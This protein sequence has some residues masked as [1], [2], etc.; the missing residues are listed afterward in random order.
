MPKANRPLRG[1]KQEKDVGVVYKI[2]PNVKYEIGENSV[3]TVLEE[4]NR[5][6][7]NFFRRIGFKIP[8]CKKI[9]FDE[10]ASFVFLLIDGERTVSRLAELLDEK[11]GEAAHPLYERL[12][13]FLDYV[14]TERRYIYR[15]S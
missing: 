14:E 4:Q 5:R 7:Q 3:V 2:T 6:I 11:Y 8:L 13:L 9:E 12:W 1:A 15:K 10:Y